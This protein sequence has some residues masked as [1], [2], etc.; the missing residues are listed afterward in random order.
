MPKDPKVDA[1]EDCVLLGSLPPAPS[2]PKEQHLRL[3]ARSHELVAESRR[4]LEESRKLVPP[5]ARY[6]RC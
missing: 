4:I 2:P 5:D 3:I 1:D 6:S